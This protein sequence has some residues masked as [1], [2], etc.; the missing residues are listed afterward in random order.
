MSGQT[1][2]RTPAEGAPNTGVKATQHGLSILGAKVFFILSGLLQQVFLG[3]VLGMSGYGALSTALSA[4][5]IV[6]NPIVQSSLQGVSRTV[7]Q[8]HAHPQ[9]AL[10]QTLRVHIGAAVGVA[11]GFAF[12]AEPLAAWMGAPHLTNTLRAL[13]AILLIY[14]LYAPL[15]GALNG[16]GRLHQQAFFDVLSATLRTLGLIFGAYLGQRNWPQDPGGGALGASLGFIVSSVIVLLTSAIVAGVGE[17][18]GRSPTARQYLKR[19]LPL[20]LGQVLL[21]ALFQ[22]DALL[23]RRFAASAALAEQGSEL[24]AD[25]YVG[26]YRAAQLFSF[27]PYQLLSSVTLVL[28]PLL[29]R[30]QAREDKSV[31]AAY[32]S[33][34][35][36]LALIALGVM[37][38]VLVAFPNALV[39]LVYGAEAAALGGPALSVLGPSLGLLALLGVLT[40]CLN[41]LGQERRTFIAMFIA[42]VAVLATATLLTRG[43]PLG[44]PLLVK[45]AQ[46]TGVGLLIA[47]IV[48]GWFLYQEVGGWVRVMSAIRIAGAVAL[49]G[50]LGRFLEPSRALW[51]VLLAPLLLLVY[52]ALLTVSGELTRKDLASFRPRRSSS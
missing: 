49:T 19:L 10:R 41:S 16:T 37:L 32:V 25:P 6:Y 42:V 43:V 51:V 29:A 5:S 46:G 1:A 21:N 12:F 8:D 14:G 11:L 48:A 17:R 3:R 27:L 13:S 22:A 40:T 30:A 44:A 2:E 34:G 52:V 18:G 26:A 33:Q 47:T 35:T 7:A 50:I 28:F 15:I 20:F 4:C 39:R 38:S 9:K 23:L 36:R 31:V 45:T 24:L